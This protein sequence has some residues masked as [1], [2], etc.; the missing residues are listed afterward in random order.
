MFAF[1]PQL[2]R[3]LTNFHVDP[4]KD[5]FFVCFLCL[6][7]AMA[8]IRPASK[9]LCKKADFYF[10]GLS[11]MSFVGQARPQ[12]ADI[13]TTTTSIQNIFIYATKL[14]FW[15]TNRNLYEHA[16]I[17]PE[18]GLNFFSFRESKSKLFS[19]LSD[20]RGNARCRTF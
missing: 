16:N 6:L 13:F 19:F 20:F 11:Q 3:L 10:Y 4:L 12:L 9:N 8:N 2:L 14:I 18:G 15:L 5:L 7:F 17:E 1:F